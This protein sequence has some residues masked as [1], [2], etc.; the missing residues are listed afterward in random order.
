[1]PPG[2]RRG[3]I[4]VVLEL[5]VLVPLLEAVLPV[6][7]PDPDLDADPVTV[8]EPVGVMVARSVLEAVED[9][10][11]DADSVGLSSCRGPMRA[12]MFLW[13]DA[14]HG[15]ADEQATKMSRRVERRGRV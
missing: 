2:G 6:P 9:A 5:V 12:L 13:K 1:M 14:G 4:A 7:D 3:S 10:D 8:A 11:E 15:H